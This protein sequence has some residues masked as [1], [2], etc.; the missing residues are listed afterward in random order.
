VKVPVPTEGEVRAF[1]VVTQAAPGVPVPYVAAVVDCGGTSVRANII[2][3]EPDP[4]HVRLGM[5]VALRTYVAGTDDTGVDAVN[6][7]F[8]PVEGDHE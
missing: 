2:A 8:A 3:V 4:E 1:T 7:G 5:K 6:F